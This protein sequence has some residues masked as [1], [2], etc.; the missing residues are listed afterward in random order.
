MN[1]SFWVNIN[2]HGLVCI[3]LVQN[4]TTPKQNRI[5]RIPCRDK[6]W[7]KSIASHCFCNALWVHCTVE[8]TVIYCGL[9]FFLVDSYLRV[10]CQQADVNSQW[11]AAHSVLQQ[12][13]SAFPMNSSPLHAAAWCINYKQRSAARRHEAHRLSCRLWLAGCFVAAHALLE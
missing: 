4:P 13:I 3:G 6:M 2:N 10:V 9:D 12:L 5:R 8:Q 11:G 1:V 7:K